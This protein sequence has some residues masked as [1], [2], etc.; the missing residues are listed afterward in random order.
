[1][2]FEAVE[3]ILISYPLLYGALKFFGVIVFAFLSHLIT[4]K[5]VLSGIKKI[6]SKTKTNLD[7][8]LFSPKMLGRVSLIVPIIILNEFTYLIPVGAEFL[9]RMF[10]SMIAFLIMLSIAALLDSF[11]DIYKN[12]RKFR[13]RPIKGYVQVIKII[14]YIW[15][16]IVI[17]GLLTGQSPWTLLGGIGAMTAVILLVF[18]DTILS[19]VASIQITSYDLVKIGD[20][21]EIPKY[22]VDGDVID[23]SLNVI[24]IQNFDKTITTVPTYKLIEESFKNWRGMQQAG[25]RRIKR[26]I[27]IDQSSIKFLDKKLTAKFEKFA[28][29]ND[30]ILRVKKEV[31]E[32][33]KIHK[34]D[35]TQIVNGRRLTN[36]GTFRAYLREYL[37]R[38]EDINK[39]LTFLIRQLPPGPEGIPIEIYVF[40]N[41]TEWGLYEDIQADIFDHILAVVP[42]FDLNIF[43]NPSGKDFQKLFTK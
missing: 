4:K 3:K 18:K 21:I 10:E 34:V 36:L 8:L 26:S 41:T 2:N 35:E 39:N 19:F 28:V 38:R 11:H 40:A 43:Q 17:A 14:V 31:D 33:N 16:G 22:G 15:G 24:K 20:W 6:V 29:L 1:M 5:I 42:Q 30:Y 25:G 23:I 32:Y 37:K 12:K 7:D 9:S 13:N 27:H